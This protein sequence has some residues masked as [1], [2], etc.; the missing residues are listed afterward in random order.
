ME[1]NKGVT[2]IRGKVWR[3]DKEPTD[4]S[5]ILYK[6][7]KVLLAIV[8]FNFIVAKRLTTSIN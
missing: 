6:V 2:I 4:L 1:A 7:E 5:K 3:M 8:S